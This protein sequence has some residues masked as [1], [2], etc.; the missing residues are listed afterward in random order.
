MYGVIR[1]EVAKGRSVI[2]SLARVMKGKNVSMEVK[3]GLRNSILLPGLTYGSETWRWNRAQHSRVGA[4][5][6]SYLRGPCGVTR[7]KGERNENVYERCSM[8]A[9]ANEVW[10]GGMCKKMH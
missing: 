5:E 9:C 8:G 6:M 1:E 2:G 10:S 4:V 3:K 7:W